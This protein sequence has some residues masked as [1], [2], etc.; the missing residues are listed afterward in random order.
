MHRINFL[1][2]GFSSKLYLW[3]GLVSPL[4]EGN[5]CPGVVVVEDRARCGEQEEGLQQGEPE[6]SGDQTTRHLTAKK[7]R[8]KWIDVSP[9]CNTLFHKAF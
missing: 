7:R 1:Q 5:V 6:P 8:V 3:I 4:V 2:S 9:L